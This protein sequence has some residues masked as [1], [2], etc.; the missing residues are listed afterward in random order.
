[1][2][3]LSHVEWRQIHQLLRLDRQS[4]A[5]ARSQLL[6]ALSEDDEHML[7]TLLH[8]THACSNGVGLSNAGGASTRSDAAAVLSALHP[9][10]LFLAFLSTLAFDHSLLLDYLIDA[11]TP[12]ALPYLT[13]VLKRIT[14]QP[15]E[16]A[17]FAELAAASDDECESDAESPL[18]ACLACLIRLRMA[19]QRL[20]AKRL[21]PYPAG[22]LLALL[23]ALEAAYEAAGAAM[24]ACADSTAGGM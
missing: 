10:S 3:S 21:F 9:Y 4:A 1:M 17:R 24:Q 6:H 12:S 23:L 15:G 22:P 14:A 8:L 20:E 2:A 18:D 5:E 13:L 7:C 11:D 16:F 19:V